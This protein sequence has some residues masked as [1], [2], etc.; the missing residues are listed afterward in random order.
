MEER[1]V[2][3][4]EFVE[5]V[6]SHLTREQLNYS[7]RVLH[8]GRALLAPGHVYIVGKNPGG[9]PQQKD[10]PD[11]TVCSIR[12]DLRRWAEERPDHYCAPRDDTTWN[13]KLV[14]GYEAVL[15][16]VGTNPW[17]VVSSNVIF[18][19]GANGLPP[20]PK[21]EWF[22]RCMEVHRLILGIVRPQRIVI[23][24]NERGQTADWF[25]SALRAAEIGEATA[26]AGWGD[27]RLRAW[28]GELEG[29]PFRLLGFPHFSYCTAYDADRRQRWVPWLRQWW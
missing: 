19:R 27:Y 8:T 4:R 22:P 14:A 6:A 18:G 16:F 11:P 13:S 2:E 5:R 15:Q 20:R 21:T 12:E 28:E 29:R 9:A 3:S 10:P 17:S 1:C 24:G 25:A 26:E 23:Y 7:G